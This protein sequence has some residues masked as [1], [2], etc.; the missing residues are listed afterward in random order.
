MIEA[1]SVSSVRA[2]ETA[3]MGE[4]PPGTLMDRARRA[5][6]P[7]SS[8]SACA[9]GAGTPRRRPRRRRGQRRRRPVRRRRARRGGRGRRRGHP[10]G[11]PAR[12]RAGRGDRAP[13]SRSSPRSAARQPRAPSSWSRRRTSSSTAS[14]ASA[15]GPGCRPAA[16]AV[17]RAVPDESMVIAVDLPSGADPAG[18]SSAPSMRVRRRDGDVRRRQAGAPAAGHRARGAGCS[19]WSTSGS[20]VRRAGRGPAA[21]PRRR[22]RALAGARPRRRQVLPR[23]PRR[24][25]RRRGLHRAPPCSASPRAV[26]AGAGMVRYVGP[27]TPTLLVRSAVPEAVHGV[28]RVQ[29]WLVGPGLD[30]AE[31]R[32]STAARSAAPRWTPWPRASRASWTPGRST[33]SSGTRV[34]RPPCSRRTPASWP[35]CSPGSTSRSSAA[36]V[37]AAPV[38][39]ARRLAE[40]TGATVLLKGATTL[41]VDPERR[42]RCAPRRTRRRGWPRPGPAT[43][44]PAW[45]ARCSRRG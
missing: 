15:A 45:S 3:A 38:R 4:L 30:A 21:D 6:S 37:T 14:S 2:A 43:C 25:R 19:P 29:A 40:L 32:P 26:A 36:D 10:R 9:S 28:G 22:G 11:A 12:G 42:G 8:P 24:R 20:T 34:P 31:R 18:E 13:G 33:C 7:T 35:G 1:Y 27:P 44:W 5:A 23:R 39:H 16:E 17:V 41:V